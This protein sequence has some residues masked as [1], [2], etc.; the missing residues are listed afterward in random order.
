MHRTAKEII[1]ACHRS[2]I[3]ISLHLKCNKFMKF[4][5][6]NRFPEA[7]PDSIFQTEQNVDRLVQRQKLL[8]LYILYVYKRLSLSHFLTEESTI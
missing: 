7:K 3:G 6:R 8:S 5:K 1:Y 4:R 2:I